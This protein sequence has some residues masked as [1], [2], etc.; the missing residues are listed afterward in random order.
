M[1]HIH[2][3]IARFSFVLFVYFYGVKTIKAR[4]VS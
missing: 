1:L 4:P 2:I 3:P